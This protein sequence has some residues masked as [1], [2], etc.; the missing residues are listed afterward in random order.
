MTNPVIPS[1]HSQFGGAK[2][3]GAREYENL[4]LDQDKPITVRF[5]PAMH[6]LREA[7]TWKIFHKQ[8]FGYKIINPYDPT[9]FLDKVFGCVEEED[10][11]T[12]MIRVSCPECRNIE[13]HEKIRDDAVAVATAQLKGRGILDV[14]SI[15]ANLKTNPDVVAARAWLYT[16]NRDCKWFCNV[17]TLDGKLGVLRFANKAMKK[18]NDLI[19]NLRKQGIEPISDLDKGVYFTLTRTG[20]FG[21]T[22][23][24]VEEYM[25]E[26]PNNEGKRRKWAGLPD[27]ILNLAVKN[28]PDLTTIPHMI[29]NAQIKLLVESDGAPESV[30]LIFKMSE[31]RKDRQ[32]TA[33]SSTATLPPAAMAA[34][35]VTKP[36]PVAPVVTPVTIAAPTEEQIR[37]RVEA[38]IAKR[39]AA[40]SVPAPMAAAPA[41]PSVASGV[42]PSVLD[43]NVSPA[44]FAAKFGKLPP[45]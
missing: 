33:Q 40:L 24:L 3:N 39:M 30:E 22:D 23:F 32:Q 10:Y 19:S 4:K 20:T 42:D 37:V 7:G 38:E 13:A 41:A 18:L 25:E 36:A 21:T 29:S 9:K 35:P 14:Q 27:T 2:N 34:V 43:P 15:E 5:L 12:H 26:L 1:I 28:L 11:K 16:H 31:D 44:D 45:R 6:S 17:V 8:H